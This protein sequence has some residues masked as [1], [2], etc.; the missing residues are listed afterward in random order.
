MEPRERQCPGQSW[1]RA[2]HRVPWKCQAKGSGQRGRNNQVL[3][4]RSRDC[5]PRMRQAVQDRWEAEPGV[6]RVIV[7]GLFRVPS[8]FYLNII[9]PSS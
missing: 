4:Q 5:D 9:E 2:K 3:G 8:W 7:M 1:E 6:P